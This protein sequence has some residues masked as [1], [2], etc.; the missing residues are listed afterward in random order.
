MDK[1]K[2]TILHTLIKEYVKTAQPVSS[3]I[4]VEKYRLDV[5]PATVRNDM[6]SLEEEEY[7]TQPHTSAGRI[8]TEK[9]FKLFIKEIKTKKIKDAE[10]GELSE[11]L[12]I[13]N[14]ENFK[15]A[16]KL[17]S[18]YANLAVFWAFHRRNLYYTGISN[19]FAQPEFINSSVVY[20]ISLIVDEMD[21]IIESIFDKFEFIPEIKIGSENPFSPLCGTILTKYRLK[22]GIGMFGILGP[23]RMDYARNLSLISQV[24]EM[25]END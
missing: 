15:K 1:R 5:S 12:K 7:I 25:L 19:L 18:Q 16:S 8:P 4:L 21:V 3:G 24:K 6:A 14:E 9:A 22:S 13:K 11:L 17:I 20:D 10:T 23:I 2:E